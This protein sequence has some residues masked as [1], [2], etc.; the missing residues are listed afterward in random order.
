MKKSNIRTEI[1]RSF[2]VKEALGSGAIVVAWPRWP[3]AGVL[4]VTETLLL[5]DT[6][7][8]RVQNQFVERESVRGKGLFL[9]GCR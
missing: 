8:V 5:A 3:G 2:F 9:A 7:I 1:A 4:C 6:K